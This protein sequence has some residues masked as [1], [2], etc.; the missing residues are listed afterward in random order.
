MMLPI[1]LT[2]PQR[3]ARYYQK[4]DSQ[5]QTNQVMFVRYYVGNSDRANLGYFEVSAVHANDVAN[6][7]INGRPYAPLLSY[8]VTHV[9]PPSQCMSGSREDREYYVTDTF[10]QAMM[11]V[12]LL[13]SDAHVYTT[14]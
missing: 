13:T 2:E 12:A 1:P 14:R 7:E 11:L 8:D 9:L 6:R 4:K 3:R 5:Q 10:S